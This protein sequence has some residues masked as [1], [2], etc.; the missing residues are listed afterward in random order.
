MSEKRFK[1]EVISKYSHKFSVLEVFHNVPCDIFHVDVPVWSSFA[2]HNESVSYEDKCN[3]SIN[4]E[5]IC[6]NKYFCK[7]FS[8]R[9]YTKEK[10]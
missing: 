1:K 10:I 3:H 7:Y 4:S 8:V 9:C 6:T 2:F 5:C